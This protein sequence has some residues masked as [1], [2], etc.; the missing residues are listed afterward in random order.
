MIKY[1]FF[2]TP[3]FAAIILDQLIKSGLIPVAIVTNPDRPVG[4]KKLITPSPVKVAAGNI[5]VLQPENLDATFIENLKNFNAEVGILAAYGKIISPAVFKIFPKGIIVVHPSLLPKYRGA[6]PIQTA[7]LNGD[8]ET[9]AALFLMDKKIDHGYIISNFQVSIFNDDNYETLMK[10]LAVVSADL[11]IKNVPK[12]LNGE[13]EPLPQ[14]E[15]QATY[16]KKFSTEDGRVN[17][18][19]DE[20]ELIW[21]KV[22]ALN[23]ETGALTLLQA[24]G[25]LKRMKILEADLIEGKLVLKKIQFEG[26]K[27]KIMNPPRAASCAVSGEDSRRGVGSADP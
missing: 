16:T 27:P 6:T 15:S 25:K 23:P 1:V 5:S 22:R 21:R 9:G 18:D 19:K 8:K 7:I 10:K 11:L 20:P 26:E 24:Q 3:E 14:D 4:R 12:Y 13:I 2:G 17:L